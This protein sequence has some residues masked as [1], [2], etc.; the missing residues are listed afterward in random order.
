MTKKVKADFGVGSFEEPTLSKP[1]SV[2]YDGEE[3]PELWR[4]EKLKKYID[5]CDDT[6]YHAKMNLKFF[7][8]VYGLKMSPEIIQEMAKVQAYITQRTNWKTF[9][10]E[11]CRLIQEPKGDAGNLK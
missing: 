1:S 10:Q 2:N 11:Q 4:I 5:E 8:R 7:Q 3:Y 9:L 6:I